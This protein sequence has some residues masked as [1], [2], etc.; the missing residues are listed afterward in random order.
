MANEERVNRV[1]RLL[2]RTHH[3][4]AVAE[5]CTGGAIAAALTSLAGSSGWFE[6]GF[7]AYSNRAKVEM[8]GVDQETLD[9]HG[10]V[11]EQTVIEMARGALERSRASLSM[12]VSGVAGP[13]GGS[14]DKPV[15]TVWL[16]WAI[17]E[18]T[19]HTRLACFEGNRAKIRE[20]SIDA[21]L[22]GLI[23]LITRQSGE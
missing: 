13:G 16:A 20:Q 14:P 4:L 17:D 3:C 12:A 11:S 5:S 2:S 19:V 1:A 10:S 15:G 21:A 7:T 18:A 23:E 22:A 9:R 8:L 6:R